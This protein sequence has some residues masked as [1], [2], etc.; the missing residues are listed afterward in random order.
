MSEREERNKQNVQA[1]YEMMFNEC[2]P[3][4]AVDRFVGDTYTQ[5]NPMVGDGKQA[6]IDYFERMAGEYPGKRVRFVRVIAEGDYVVLHCHQTWPGGPDWAGI[7]IFRLDEDGKVV[8]HWDVLQT[9]PEKS[10]N[11]NGMF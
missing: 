3:A 6:F 9:V 7:D 11:E 10:A 8:E 2:R 4:D 5:H 1:F